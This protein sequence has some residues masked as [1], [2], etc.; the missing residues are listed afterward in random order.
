MRVFDK[1]SFKELRFGR[2]FNKQ[3]HYSLTY[4]F[5]SAIDN[6]EN[7]K[8]DIKFSLKFEW[9]IQKRTSNY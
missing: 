1:L 3:K 9:F 4:L 8:F 2:N 5:Y 7:K 6:V